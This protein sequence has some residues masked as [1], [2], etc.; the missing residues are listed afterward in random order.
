MVGRRSQSLAS[1]TAP[2]L[3]ARERPRR[4]DSQRRSLHL[5]MR[6]G[7][8]IALD[9][10]LPP[11]AAG[12]RLPTMV[13]QT[14]YFRSVAFREPYARLP[15]EWLV[16]SS[17]LTRER[18]VANGYAWVDVCTRGSGASFGTRPCPWSPE[19]VRDG[20]QIAAWIVRQPWSN[21]RIGATGISYDGTTAELLLVNN[22]PAVKAVAPRFSCYDVFADVAFPGGIHLSGFTAKWAGFNRDLDDNRLDRAFATMIRVQL[23]AL[24]ELY[25]RPHPDVV[26]A[27][28]ARLLALADSEGGEA[29]VGFVLRRLAAGVR[30]VDGDHGEVLR[31]A[32]ASHRT[33]SDVHLA[34]LDIDYRDDAGMAPGYPDADM[35]LFSPHAYAAEMAPSEAAIY[36]YSG[37]LDGAYANSAAKRFRATRAGASRLILGPWDHGGRQHISPFC[38]APLSAFDHDGEL[39]SFFDAH[40][41]Q[42]D[43]AA[44]DAPAVRYFIQGAERWSSSDRWPPPCTWQCWHLGDE[45]SLSRQPSL[46]RGHDDYRVDPQLGTGLRARWMSLLGLLPPVGYGDRRRA[47]ERM[48]VYRSAPLSH[49]LEIT[50]HPRIDFTLSSSYSD[51]HL[52]VYL[53]AERPDGRVMYITEGQLR[54]LHR[55]HREVDGHIERS[56]RHADARPLVAGEPARCMVEL[57]PTSWLMRPGWRLRVALAGAD[58][59]HFESLEVTPTLTVH[60]GGEGGST[61]WLPVVGATS[62]GS[63]I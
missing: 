46:S 39:L 62:H 23:G 1:D 44:L 29:V 54:A 11:D 14:R 24:R 58:C 3:P 38:E 56:Y 43:T 53:E 6:D 30:P 28:C 45:R 40:L 18:F 33:N 55:A 26:A 25:R 21:G 41:R 37:W 17:A 32:I 61:L 31:A 7:V 16:N 8:R 12:K 52:F 60:H 20:A 4:V 9:V 35:D 2:W 19:E 10:H 47:G 36:G 59:D 57:L 15:L 34:A 5:T 63:N 50:G 48:L 22:H 13:R 27:T 49:P 51:A 42:R